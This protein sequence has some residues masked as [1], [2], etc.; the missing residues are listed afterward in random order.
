MPL[1]RQ[2]SIGLGVGVLNI[3]DE[4]VDA[5][6]MRQLDLVINQYVDDRVIAYVRKD[7]NDVGIRV[8]K[9]EELRD[10]R[11]KKILSI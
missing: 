5:H 11:A 3:W 2:E 4:Y 9:L 6:S 1:T 8:V 10:L 7:G